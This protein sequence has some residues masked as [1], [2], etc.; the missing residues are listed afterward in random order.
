MRRLVVERELLTL[1]WRPAAGPFFIAVVFA[2][3]VF[4]YN[5]TTHIAAI[6]R[7]IY[8][9]TIALAF[10]LSIYGIVSAFRINII[11]SGLSFLIHFAPVLIVYV[12]LF[13]I[14]I[15]SLVFAVTIKFIFIAR[16]LYLFM[17]EPDRCSETIGMGGAT[18]APEKC[19]RC[20][21]GRRGPLP[22]S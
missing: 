10:D 7:A 5:T 17:Y 15:I 8:I 18:S 4:T 21:T 2:A 19:A 1:P 3:V 22:F 11:A 9:I 6:V 20:R 13:L 12:M 16:V 14:V